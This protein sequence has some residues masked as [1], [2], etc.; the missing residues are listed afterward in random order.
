MTHPF[1]PLFGKRYDLVTYRYNWGENRVYFH[2]KNRGLISIPASWTDIKAK[3]PFVKVS[4][5]R[6]YFR[7]IDLLELTEFIKNAN[8]EKGEKQKKSKKTV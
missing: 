1:H 2:D 7:L 4:S 6:S 8:A 3:D 5:G